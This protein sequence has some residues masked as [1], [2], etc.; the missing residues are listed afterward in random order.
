MQR[1]DQH[2]RNR[3]AQ[4]RWRRP[5]RHHDPRRDLRATSLTIGGGYDGSRDELSA[6]LAARLPEPGSKHH[7][8]G[9]LRRR[10]HRRQRRRRAATIRASISTDACTPGALT[11]PTR[12]RS[13]ATGTLTLSGRY[14][15]HERPEHGRHPVRRCPD[16]S[17]AD[18][19]FGRFNPA[20][21]V[22]FNPSRTLNVYAGY[23]EGSRAPTSI[24]LGCADPDLPCKLPNAM[25]GDPPL[26]QVVTQDRRGRR[27][28]R[29]VAEQPDQL[30]RR[31][32]HR[33]TTSTTSCSSR[34][35]NQVSAISRTSAIRGGRVSN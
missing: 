32:L 17:T 19:S 33:R 8:R 14:N 2:D 6:V 26:D 13:A 5:D 24:E 12:S 15:R 27:P 20:A 28:R 35:R 4:L 16:P 34:R 11:A 7:R 1:A 31:F 3:P 23:S 21:G 10:R 29:H 9:R 25:A 30:E 22:T 18:Y